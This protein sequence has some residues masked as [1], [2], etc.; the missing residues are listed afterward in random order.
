[1]EAVDFHIEIIEDP[2]GPE[3]EHGEA[4]Q[5][6]GPRSGGRPLRVIQPDQE[7]PQGGRDAT[8][9]VGMGEA[10]RETDGG[11]RAHFARHGSAEA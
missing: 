2:E 5:P 11:H 7:G 6:R 10:E 8:R 3:L 4:P 1:M 9:I